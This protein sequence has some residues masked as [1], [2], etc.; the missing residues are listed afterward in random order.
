MLHH[1]GYEN[2]T[3]LPNENCVNVCTCLSLSLCVRVCVCVC[4]CVVILHV[5][6]IL[7][8]VS[9]S[10]C[11]E[12]WMSCTEAQLFVLYTVCHIMFNIILYSLLIFSKV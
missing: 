8:I 3:I 2:M 11:Y 6:L 7:K 9:I 1:Y 10:W 12:S 5:E 4:V